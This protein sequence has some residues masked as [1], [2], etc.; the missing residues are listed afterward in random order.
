[1]LVNIYARPSTS[2]QRP[3]KLS[4]TVRRTWIDDYTDHENTIVLLQHCLLAECKTFA[5]F[6]NRHKQLLTQHLIRRILRKINLIETWGQCKSS[7]TANKIEHITCMG[8][9][10]SVGF[11]IS[12]VYRKPLYPLNPLEIQESTQRYP[13]CTRRK[14]KDLR[15]LI[16]IEGF[17]GAPPPDNIGIW[18]RIP[19]IFCCRSPLVYIDVGSSRNKQFKFLL[20]E[21]RKK[22]VNSQT[23]RATSPA[24][25]S[26]QVFCN[27]FI[28]SIGETL[29]LVLDRGVESILSR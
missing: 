13:G 2:G 3:S 4:N 18:T 22:I 11:S 25:D 6:I 20:I 23:L 29:Y 14:T 5:T 9:R 15:S 12:S 24:Y 26:D 16:P 19:V 17:E 27:D 8:L 1:M 28:K 10:K 21:L 7:I